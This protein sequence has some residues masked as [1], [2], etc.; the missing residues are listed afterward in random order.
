[1]EVTKDLKDK[2]HDAVV[3]AL[4]A[5]TTSEEVDVH[6]VDAIADVLA[7]VAEPKVKVFGQLPVKYV[8]RRETYSDG[9]FE[10]GVWVKGQTKMVATAIAGRML[11]HK[12]VYVPGEAADD[13]EVV[14]QQEKSDDAPDSEKLMA[15]KQ[16]V[17]N[18]T[19]KAAVQD[20]VAANYNGLK[21]PAEYTNLNDMKA[22]AIRQIDIYS[23]P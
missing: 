6:L 11:E 15:A 10:T 12:D 1:M 9:L 22:F 18:M 14:L 21:I 3:I 4:A 2:L 16:A 20:F 17:Q 13:A 23:L 19:R 5:Y 7:G 8:G